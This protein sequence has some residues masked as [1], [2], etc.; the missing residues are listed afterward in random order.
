MLANFSEK[1]VL[2]HPSSI[3]SYYLFQDSPDPL[4]GSVLVVLGVPGQQFQDSLSAIRQP[5]KHVG[6]GATPVNGKVIFP[7]SLSHSEERE[8]LLLS[9]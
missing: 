4:S 5:G 1:Y 2:I 6:E 3:P 7:L 9:L 8:D